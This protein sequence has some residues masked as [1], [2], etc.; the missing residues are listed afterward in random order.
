MSSSSTEVFT[1]NNLICKKSWTCYLSGCLCPLP[2]LLCSES[3]GVFYFLTRFCAPL[4]WSCCGTSSLFGLGRRMANL[5]IF[6]LTFLTV[7]LFA[8]LYT[9]FIIDV[10][11][12]F[13]LLTDVFLRN[14]SVKV[15][16]LIW[17][18]KIQKTLKKLE[19]PTPMKTLFSVFLNMKH[20]S[21]CTGP[22]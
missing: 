2:F 8:L 20:L 19:R 17:T 22:I 18:K 16:Q 9:I 13:W 12:L 4:F 15:R 11:F 6:F 7:D 3:V 1:L 10:T 5:C 14:C 21:H